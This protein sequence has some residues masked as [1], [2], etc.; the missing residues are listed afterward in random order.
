MQSAYKHLGY[1]CAERGGGSTRN[2]AICRNHGH[3]LG[4]DVCAT[5]ATVVSAKQ[6]T[7]PTFDP[8]ACCARQD[9]WRLQ[10]CQA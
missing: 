8:E 4:N 9:V 3:R 6:E 10:A 5:P 7:D 1:D 2:E